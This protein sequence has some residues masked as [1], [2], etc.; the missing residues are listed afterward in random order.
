MAM[1]ESHPLAGI[2]AR[3]G[4]IDPA[5]VLIWLT[6]SAIAIFLALI[7]VDS[8]VI[9]GLY[10]PRTNDSLYH[11]RRILDA[12]VGSRGF[13]EF[14]ERLHV[15]DG[16]WIPWPWA[17]DYLMSRLA[18]FGVWLDPGSD[19]LALIFYVPVAWILVNAA[20][21]LAI[22][23]AIRLSTE[24][25]WLAMLCFALSPLTQLLH[26][27]GMLDHHYVEHTFV[28]LCVC[29]GIRWFEKLASSGRAIALGATLGV[30]P[31]FHN[32]L[33]I[34]QLIPLGA[35]LVLWLRGGALP[36]PS[37]R[38]FAIALLVA[39]QLVLLPS[40]PYRQGM[41]EFGLLSWFHFYVAMCTAATVLF[42]AHTTFSP[43]YLALFGVGCAALLAPLG[44]QILS[45]AG[46]LSGSFSILGGIT[47]AQSVYALSSMFGLTMPASF[48]SWLMLAAPVLAAFFAYRLFRETVPGRLYFTLAAAFGLLLL[49][50]QFRLHYYGFFA[51]V[52]GPLLVLDAL[53]A[54][55]RWHRGAVL[56]ASAAALT[57][58]FQPALRERLFVPLAPGDN[59]DYASLLPLY[60][61]LERFCAAEPGVVLTH[62]DNGS[63]VLFHTDCPVIANNFILRQAD[64]APIEAVSRLLDGTPQEIRR[65][66]PDVK[67]VLLRARDY[68][69]SLGGNTG[70]DPKNPVAQE[71]LTDRAPPEGFEL[72]KTVLLEVDSTGETAVLARLY[73]VH[74]L[75]TNGVNA[76]P[77]GAD[78]RPLSQ[79]SG[80]AGTH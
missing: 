68:V 64:V 78:G 47:E 53:R 56:A 46:F 23:R 65:Q 9:D 28:L 29:L 67:Y 41:F 4:K 58:A 10:I 57:L 51:L 71:L 12:A 60:L 44:P 34:L 36:R 21:L 43:R 76:L 26:G 13:Y 22:C 16:T 55:F 11:A 15:P 31:A 40:E 62:T 8:A 37:L 80:S 5:A 77:N 61:E 17:Y 63:A 79:L 35:F 27:V 32:G 39:T 18:A 59:P 38:A 3:V 6:A 42:F 69:I 24:M 2:A 25:Q 73:R 70:L 72:L 45:G 52:T 30:A 66:R 49:L 75:E 50:S 14:D 1:N 48:Y 20:L 33:F 74:P 54:R 19:P 7:L